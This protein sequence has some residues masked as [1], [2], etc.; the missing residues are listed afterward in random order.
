MHPLHLF[1]K[2]FVEK[3]HIDYIFDKRTSLQ[4]SSPSDIFLMGDGV[5][6]TVVAIEVAMVIVMHN[7]SADGGMF[8]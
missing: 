3:F 2:K 1:G 7:M 6:I 8:S 4:F 5:A